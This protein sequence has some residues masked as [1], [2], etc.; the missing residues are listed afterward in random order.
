MRR[1]EGR[2]LFEPSVLFGIFEKDD[3]FFG[4]GCYLFR[5]FTYKSIGLINNYMKGGEK[6]V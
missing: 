5:G 3:S 2:G 1:Y 6:P 4:F